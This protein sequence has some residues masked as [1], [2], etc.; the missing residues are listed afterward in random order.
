MSREITQT[1]TMQE[2]SHTAPVSKEYTVGNKRKM[3][4]RQESLVKLLKPCHSVADSLLSA[5]N[6]F[7][8]NYR[9]IVT[10]VIIILF[11]SNVK[12]AFSN[13]SKYGIRVRPLGVYT[14]CV[15]FFM[16]PYNWPCICLLLGYPIVVTVILQV[17]KLL[18]QKRISPNLGVI[19]H[20]IT[21]S[22][23]LGV[24]AGVLFSVQHSPIAAFFI[25]LGYS[26]LWLKMISYVEV[27]HWE[28]EM[29]KGNYNSTKTMKN[30]STKETL[31]TYPNNLNYRDII[32]FVFVPTLCYELNF[33]RTEKIRIGFMFRR[34]A[35][36]I[37]LFQLL[38][39]LVQQWVIPG[40]E[41]SMK[42]LRDMELHRL[43]ERL[44]S[45]AIPNHFIWLIMFYGYFH[46]F[47][48]FLGEATRFG[49]RRFYRD[50]W[51]AQ[52]IR[53]FWTHW[54]VPTHRWLV[55]HV[56]KPMLSQGYSKR[57]SFFFVFLLSSFF[58]EYL[59]SIPL[60]MLRLWAFIGM[61]IQVPFSLITEMFFK[62]D[63][64]NGAM[65]FSIIVGQPAIILMYVHDYFYL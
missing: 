47:F 56:Y 40:I 32:Y 22:A 57:T 15:E 28:R 19:I 39:F 59:V 54:N 38:I 34:L 61:L 35:E 60:R 3:F 65:W 55:R 29:I 5:Q 9:G 64:G 62:G 44:F 26:I 1:L 46:C 12:N 33:P 7:E 49:D 14:W 6:K 41:S 51:N 10:W 25:L 48:N 17:E 58:H 11:C 24:P 31:V 21:F 16:D 43:V 63:Y 52:T 18:S 23:I 8:M 53:E 45:L 2:P 30:E 13:I 20:S 27:N 37:L 42:P 36:F 4:T 50:W